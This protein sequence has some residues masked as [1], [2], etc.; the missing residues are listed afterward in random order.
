MILRTRFLSLC[1]VLA[2]AGLAPLGCSDDAGAFGRGGAGGDGDGVGPTDL[3]SDQGPF[4][5]GG[6]G[7][8]M[9]AAL[10]PSGAHRL[11][12]RQRR[13]TVRDTFEPLLGAEGAEAVV[14]AAF[15]AAPPPTES[16]RY[17]RW[18][19]DFGNT[20]AQSFFVVADA[21]AKGATSPERY[22]DFVKRAVA[23]DPGGCASVEPDALSAVCQGQL[24]KNLGARFL[25]H[26]V[27]DDDAAA[28]AGELAGAPGAVGVANLV[29]RLLLAPR[30]LFHLEIDER[31]VEG[32]TDVARLSST[33][34]A[35]R[36]SY[37]FWNAP[38]DDRLRELADTT[39]LAE[40]EPFRAAVAY[41]TTHP[42]FAD[43]AR[44]FFSDWL[45]L[46]KVPTFDGAGTDLFEV[47]ADGV[48][49]DAALRGDLVNEV[50][51]LG[52]YVAT[53]GGAFRDL[54]TTEV[55]FARHAE[56]L[57]LYGVDRPAPANVTAESAVKLPP[58]THPGI[59][60]RAAVLSTASGTKNP[61]VRGARL[62]RDVLCMPLELPPNLPA[63]ALAPPAFD[64]NA[65]AR[66]RFEK[67]TL[68]GSCGGCHRAINPLG[69]ALANYSGLGRYET[70]E[71]AIT[72]D[73]A[74]ANKDLPVDATVDLAS[75]L[76]P[77]ARSSTPTELMT[78]LASRAE[79]MQCFARAY[80]EYGLARA[81]TD[82]DGCR[83]N[84]MFNRIQQGQS[85]KDVMTS[86]AMDPEFR[87]RRR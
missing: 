84:R 66:Q 80:A 70:T 31:P 51:E 75:L 19:N 23:L 87:L 26:A 2:A 13:R 63:E 71:P 76:G 5:C 78:L 8:G 15:A 52:S 81:A 79:T 38:P 64:E 18:D 77:G 82:D 11:S 9:G 22:A 39:D 21:L 16:E 55:S 40:D 33:S 30:A 42:R 41:V 67:K 20:H 12:S 54:F 43:S 60:T 46:E 32:R 72:E 61:V 85:L 48:T 47:Y 24:V 28:Y 57:K 36:L 86:L 58:G 53:Q 62:R 59:L 34:V 49:F 68:A 10:A 35:N 50:E 27:P 3:P 25:R 6:G 45:R 37:A 74:Y 44:E 29:F 56:A 17:K 69:D 7:D 4:A 65:T 14:S 73:G 83:L 1:V